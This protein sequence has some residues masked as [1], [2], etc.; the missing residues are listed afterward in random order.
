MR[1]LLAVSLIS[2]VLSVPV[3]AFA[4]MDEIIVTAQK[5]QEDGPGLFLEKRGDYLLLEVSIENDSRNF[6]TR[7]KEI[8]IAVNDFIAAAEKDSDI[9]LSIIDE[10]D[11]VRSLT[12]ENFNDGLRSGPRPDTSIAYLKVKTQIP[13]EVKDSYRLA[14][15][16][17][18]FV[19]S[20]EE[21]GRTTISTYDEISVSVV[22]P[23]QYRT[24]V[25]KLVTDEVNNVTKALG[26]EYRVMLSGLD[27]KLKWVRSG[28]LNLAFYLP[29]TYDI[30]PDTLHSIQRV[31]ED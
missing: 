16:L 25:M 26:P 11:F 4:Q 6:S 13:Y 21:K 20:I 9:T 2:F 29:Y 1:K 14:N 31:Y 30:I 19:E 8:N 23:Y 22:N 27:K 7:T 15:K 5:R 28:D 17:A 24:D 3:F 10:S 18:V 12:E